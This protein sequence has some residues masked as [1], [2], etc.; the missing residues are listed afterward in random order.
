[1]I[2]EK[3]TKE[4]EEIFR[5][6]EDGERFQNELR[7]RACLLKEFVRSKEKVSSEAMNLLAAL[8]SKCRPAKYQEFD[9]VWE[10]FTG[11]PVPKNHETTKEIVL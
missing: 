8:L 11:I 10:F 2:L 6:L 5:G 7:I 3:G 1:M 4:Y 9:E